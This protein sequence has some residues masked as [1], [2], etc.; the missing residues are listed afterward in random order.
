MN[1]TVR[2]KTETA[3]QKITNFANNIAIE[4]GIENIKITIVYCIILPNDSTKHKPNHTT[5]GSTE[6]VDGE[7]EILVD[8]E[9]DNRTQAITIAHE[10]VHVKQYANGDLKH[11]DDESGWFWKGE[12]VSVDSVYIEREWE[13][14][15]YR[16]QFKLAANALSQKS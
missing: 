14:E 1:I 11:A 8:D 9:I 5:I 12:F 16:L 4:L 13:L 15:A 3:S 7:Y 6:I 2:N 10:M